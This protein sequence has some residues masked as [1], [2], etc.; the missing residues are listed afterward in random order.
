[1]LVWFLLVA[2]VPLTIVSFIS[3]YA[4]DQS[5]R[6]AAFKSLSANVEAKAAF[7]E[8]WFDYRLLDLESQAT[9]TNNSRFLKELTDAFKNSGEDLGTFVKSY[10][11][12]I[13]A[14]KWRED[15][16]NFRSLYGYHDVFLI[17][18]EG[19]ILFTLAKENDLGTNLFVGP[20]E[21]TKF[22]VTCRKTLDTG[23]NAFS[24]LDRYSPSNKSIAGFFVS[25]IVDDH[26]EKIGLFAFQITP[27]QLAYAMRRKSGESSGIQTYVVG[28]SEEQ[29]SITL[30]TPI[31]TA[32]TPEEPAFLSRR[33]DTEQTQLWMA[34]H[35]PGRT[36][37]TLIKH[38]GFIYNGPNR[39]R[40]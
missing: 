16:K 33:V 15:L 26:G 17:D 3:F 10:R 20:L 32:I 38:R 27:E 24:D 2:L 11:W 9:N 30:H 40:L 21:G 4:A 31:E 37:K 36:E 22:A 23:Q 8:N 14:D 7:I 12:D 13:I 5:L 28:Y 18:T 34:E 39:H 6:K 25:V 19:N 35:G 1:M 29:K